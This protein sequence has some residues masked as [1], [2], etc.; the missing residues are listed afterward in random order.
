MLAGP[1][2]VYFRVYMF[3]LIVL[4]VSFTRLIIPIYLNVAWFQTLPNKCSTVI[5]GVHVAAAENEYQPHRL[6]LL[7]PHVPTGTEPGC[8]SAIF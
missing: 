4:F 2:I 7:G 1:S 5:L 3:N 6:A 8:T